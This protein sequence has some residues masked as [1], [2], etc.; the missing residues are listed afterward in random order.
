[1]SLH[2]SPP[3]FSALIIG[4]NNYESPDI[5]KLVGAVADADAVRD[6]L[7]NRLGVR[8]SQ[9]TILRD[10]EAT[11]AAIIGAI[12]A[13]SLNE[14]IKEGGPI[15]IYYAGHGGSAKT[16]ED[17]KDWSTDKIEFLVPYDYSSVK[18]NPKYGIPDRTLGALLSHL[19]NIK[20]D[21]NIVR[22]TFYPSR[23]YYQ[24]TTRQTV[25][26]DCCHSSSGTR[27]FEQKVQVLDPAYRARTIDE[28]EGTI[29]ER[30][31]TIDEREIPP[32]LDRDIWG[33]FK[34]ESGRA[35]EF[36]YGFARKGLR[37]HVLVAACHS[38]GLAYERTDSLR[39]VFT[40]ALLETLEKTGID[41]LTY[42]TLLSEMGPLSSGYVQ[43]QAESFNTKKKAANVHSIR[44]SPQCEGLSWN[45]PIFNIKASDKLERTV[46]SLSCKIRSEGEKYVIDAGE[47]AGI[48]VGAEFKVYQHQDSGDLLGTVVALDV[49]AFSTTLY[50]QEPGFALE[51]DGVAVKFC[52]GAED[53]ER[54]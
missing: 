27:V 37:S 50:A 16:P 48:T 33:V 28:G 40:M 3:R 52:A 1:M 45:R 23:V 38:R 19:A 8:S 43:A 29:D 18:D 32:D 31:R 22:Q 44:Q 6:Y 9:I 12:K 21:N 25:I 51:Q 39:G 35:S 14:E 47:A 26:L 20:G 42:A 11:R 7:Q 34:P 49:T 13:F 30:E 46:A 17:W 4:I 5:R 24:L 2:R 36:H 10:S 41:N 15:F 54:V 53:S